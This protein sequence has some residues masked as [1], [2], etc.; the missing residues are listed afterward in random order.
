MR[1]AVLAAL[2]TAA[3]AE[4]R[5]RIGINSGLVVVGTIGDD[6]R[7]D[8]TAFGDTTVLAAR[9]Q[10]AAPPGAVLVSQQSAELVRGY[11]TLKE[12]APVQVK[13]RTVYPLRVTGL[14][15]RTGRIDSGDELSPFTGRDREL[16]ELRRLL[17][18]PLAV[19]ARWWAWPVTP[20][21]ASPG[22]RWSSAGWPSPPRPC[23]RAAACPT[24]P[25]SPTCH[26]SSWCATPA[27]SPPMIPRT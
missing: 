7:V 26:C 10:A 5:I 16:A 2:G 15:T 6:L 1:G 27:G 9:L 23:W 3:Q 8:Y 19:G 21:W 22:W 20:A 25:G 12:V 17:D 13:E 4:V 14:G 11:F 18:P 24:G